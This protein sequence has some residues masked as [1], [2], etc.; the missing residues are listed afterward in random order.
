MFW[1]NIIGLTFKNNTSNKCL[2]EK[3]F[4]SIFLSVKLKIEEIYKNVFH[5]KSKNMR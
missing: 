1:E 3:T 5:G 2:E 4:F